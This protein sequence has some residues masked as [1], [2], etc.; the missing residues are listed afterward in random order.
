MNKLYNLIKG[1][2]KVISPMFHFKYNDECLGVINGVLDVYLDVYNAS[3]YR[4]EVVPIINDTFILQTE[5]DCLLLEN[6]DTAEYSTPRDFFSLKKQMLMDMEAFAN[7]TFTPTFFEDVLGDWVKRGDLFSCR[8]KAYLAWAK[9]ERGLALRLWEMLAYWGDVTSMMAL[10]FGAEKLNMIDKSQTWQRVYSLFKRDYS[11][12]FGVDQGEKRLSC[13]ESRIVDLIHCIANARW[14][15]DKS[16]LNFQL[17]DYVIGSQAS[18]EE[19]V[20]NV[21]QGD[22][23]F[24]RL[25]RE[26]GSDYY[27]KIGF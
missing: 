5:E 20:R 17:L 14:N 18:K 22:V 16:H 25:R 12:I 15:K 2:L 24:Y 10:A 27:H 1:F 8:L 26:E 11:V 23:D 21:L 19:V 9:G 3:K 13:E 6:F 4:D 7:R